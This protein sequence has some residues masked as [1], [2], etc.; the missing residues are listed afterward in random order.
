MGIIARIYIVR[1]GE[2]DANRMGVLQ[3]QMDTQLNETGIAQAKMTAEA[4]EKV[5]FL[6]AYSSDLSRAAKVRCRLHT[7]VYW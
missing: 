7:T 1:H 4:L 2:T 5:P 6:V 3:G